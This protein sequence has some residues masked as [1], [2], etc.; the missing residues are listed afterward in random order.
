MNKLSVVIVTK[1]EECNIE[2][3]LKSVKN[4]ASEIIVV[5]AFSND[6]TIDICN[7]FGCKVFQKEWE[8]FGKAKKFAV[9]QTENDW[10]FSIDAD[11][12]V[13]E[14]LKSELNKILVNPNYNVFKIK[15]R[16]FFLGKEIKHCGWNRDYPKRLFNKK[17]GNFNSDIVHESVIIEGERGKIENPI[18][19]YTYPTIKSF[20]NKMNLYSELN[21]EKLF[22][23]GKNVTIFGSMFYCI[24]R[25]IR[26]YFFDFGF[27]DGRKGFILSVI[28]SYGV[29]LKYIKLWS[30]HNSQ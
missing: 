13:S 6:K 17:Y 11:E 7:N 24:V 12:E 16:S 25:F 26:M 21:A 8:G 4:I 28:T 14:N 27:L 29:F 9:D 18:F 23:N 2:R 30:K 5:D 19:H 1:N 20:V 22:N 10:I 3:C 15:R